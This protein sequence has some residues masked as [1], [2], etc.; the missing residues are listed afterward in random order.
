MTVRAAPP[1]EKTWTG[2]SFLPWTRITSPMSRPA[3][4]RNIAFVGHPSSGKTTLVDALAF[5]IGAS[6]RKGS[7][8]DKTSICDYEP[9]EQEKQHTLQM[10]SV[11]GNWENQNWTFMD[12]PGYPEFRGEVQSSMFGADLVVGV[13]SGTS[14]VTF[15]LRT[16]MAAA[17]ELGRGRAIVITHIDLENADFDEIVADL[18]DKIGEVCVP[19]RLPNASGAGFTEV[20]RTILDAESEWCQPLKDRVMDACTD[21]DLLMEYLDSQEVS[22]AQLE[23]MLPHAISTGTIVP[24]LVCNPQD[25][26]AVDSVLEFFNRFGPSPEMIPT[27]DADGTEVGGDGSAQLQGTVFSVM[28]D[29]HVGR[30]CLA[31]ISSGTLNAHDAIA[32][33]N[34]EKPEKLGGL[35]RLVGKKR[36]SIESAGPG[37]LIAFSKVEKL[38]CWDSFSLSSDDAPHIR[39]PNVPTPMVA[40]A[41]MPKARADE[42]KIG[43][44]LHKLTAED[45]TF[46]VDHDAE[47]HELVIHGMSDLHLAVMLDRLKRRYGV[48]TET[49]IPRIT[50]HESVTKPAEGHHRHKKQSGGRGQF[51][52]CYMRIKPLASGAG[53]VFTDAVVGGSIPRNLIPAVEKGVREIAGEGIL[54]GGKVIDLEIELYDGKFHAVDSDEASFK[55]AAKGA[56]RDGFSKAGPVLLEPVMELEIHVPTEDAGAIFSDITSQRRGHVVDQA[57]EDDGAITVITATA[58]LAMVQTYHRDLK[59]Q[60]A[61]EGNFSMKFSAYARMPAGEQ[62]K[63]MAAQAKQ[64]A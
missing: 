23:E 40:L 3:S 15:N 64:E 57:N 37:D 20:R 17:K 10:A 53:V 38:T 50:Y 28:S 19:V 34:S 5:L 45:P 49:Q 25:D 51:G 56:F 59:S 47:T 43:E 13:V 2:H 58:P 11:W 63:I 60:T 4:A 24:V 42:Q 21:E 7:V 32:G 54:T 35:F 39:T 62:Q 31:R 61:G 8:A 6:A 26:V 52:E 36:E 41:V 55:M 18:R 33:P 14:G 12:T 9:E 44:A 30:I 27:V 48:E 29:P 16:K 1:V 46:V 22:E